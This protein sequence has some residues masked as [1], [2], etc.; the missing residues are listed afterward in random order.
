MSRHGQKHA[1]ACAAQFSFHYNNVSA[2]EQRAL[3]RNRKS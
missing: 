3:A 1:E 2:V